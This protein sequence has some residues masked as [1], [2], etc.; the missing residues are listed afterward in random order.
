MIADAAR[1]RSELEKLGDLPTPVRSWIVE[2]GVDAT[3]DEAVWVW[4]L[5]EERDVDAD[6]RLQLKSMA[7]KVVRDQTGGRLWPYVRIRGAFE[8]DE[9]A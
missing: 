3:D 8:E 5:L 9:T 1:I 6:T 4:A 2:E 7:R